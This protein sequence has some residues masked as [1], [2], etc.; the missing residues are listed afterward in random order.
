MGFSSYRRGWFDGGETV[1]DAFRG[2]VSSGL[3]TKSEAVAEKNLELLK[4]IFG[5]CLKLVKKFSR[6]DFPTEIP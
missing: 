3:S 6:I 5:V 4:D 2:N 1:E